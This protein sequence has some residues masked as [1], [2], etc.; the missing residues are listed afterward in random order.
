MSRSTTN[1]PKTVMIAGKPFRDAEILAVDH[2]TVERVDD[3]EKL[4][5]KDVI[6][7]IHDS[8]WLER[9]YDLINERAEMGQKV[10]LDDLIRTSFDLGNHADSRQAG[11][12]LVG[13]TIQGLE[14][15]HVSG[16]AAVAGMDTPESLTMGMLTMTDKVELEAPR[17]DGTDF[18]EENPF[19]V[20]EVE[21]SLLQRSNPAGASER[22]RN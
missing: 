21:E 17:L 14:A 12:S 11:G 1:L 8:A 3:P 18:L 7:R 9:I 5:G 4:L 20:D 15:G 10:T 22:D 13:A 16:E 2:A 19:Y 6:V